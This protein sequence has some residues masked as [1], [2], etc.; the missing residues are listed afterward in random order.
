[1]KASNTGGHHASRTE[2]ADA[3]DR[4]STHNVA[5]DASCPVRGGRTVRTILAMTY[6]LDLSPGFF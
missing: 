6:G 1:M 4:H 3:L 5:L 2:A